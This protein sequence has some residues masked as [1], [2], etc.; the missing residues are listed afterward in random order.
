[1]K[2]TYYYAKNNDAAVNQISEWHQRGTFN[3]TKILNDHQF[4]RLVSSRIWTKYGDLL[5]GFCGSSLDS[6]EADSPKQKS[7]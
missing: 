1:M 6:L 3:F 5:C 4:R 2:R 7:C